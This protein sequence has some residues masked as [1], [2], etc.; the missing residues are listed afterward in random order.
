MSAPTNQPAQLAQPA[1]ANNPPQQV[2]FQ[3]QAALQRLV[4]VCNR[5]WRLYQAQ[6][7]SG[8][9]N[10]VI[11]RAAHYNTIHDQGIQIISSRFS[12][13]IS[14]P[15]TVSQDA[16][17]NV[18]IQPLSEP[19]GRKSV[20]DP[21]PS[22]PNASNANN[23]NSASEGKNLRGKIPRPPNSFIL[24]RQ[25]HHPLLKAKNPEWH[26]NQI[27]LVLGKQWRNESEEV[28]NEFKSKAEAL[29]QQHF[30]DHPEYHYQP[31][32][33][34][35]KK[36]RM[37]RRRAEAS[38]LDGEPSS[39]SARHYASAMLQDINDGL[40]AFTNADFESELPEFDTTPSGNIVLNLGDDQLDSGTLESMLK[41]SNQGLP[42]TMISQGQHVPHMGTAALYSEPS[43]DTQD[44][45][46][47][48]SGINDPSLD[49][50]PD[51]EDV[52]NTEA[53]VTE[54]T[55]ANDQADLQHFAE[56]EYHETFEELLARMTNENGLI[57]LDNSTNGS[58]F[59][60]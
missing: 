14:A 1:N 15:V 41:F 51:I 50:R 12:N 7:D 29:K 44:E 55:M 11:V 5:L 58:W 54:I 52:E 59:D 45:H 8:I 35:E 10:S 46:N 3:Q 53:T 6:I 22:V 39:S 18:H 38:A 28:K 31:R 24:Y 42:Q 4:A 30:Q 33:P 57:S 19:L 2:N 13:M 60:F 9:K 27:S 17:G 34:S 26:N 21:G 40:K 49:Y 16:F 47:F 48:Y 43:L 25:Y 32:K 23:A 20:L 37:T 36:R 56:T